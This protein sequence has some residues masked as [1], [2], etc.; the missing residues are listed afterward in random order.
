MLIRPLPYP[1]ELDVGYAGYVMRLNG[2]ASMKDLD[3][4]MREWAGCPDKSW[5]EVSRLELISK[6]AN[7][8]VMEFVL[9]HTTLPL[10]RSITSYQADL[11]HGSDR[12]KE[13]WWSTAMR[14]ARTGAYFCESCAQED[15]DFHGRSYWRRSHQVPGV[16]SCA[17]HGGPLS[18]CRDSVA[19]QQ[20][21]SHWIGNCEMVDAAWATAVEANDTIARYLAICDGLM[22]C[23][24]PFAVDHVRAVLFHK[25]ISLGLQ[26]S[27][28][29]V[30]A[31]LLSDMVIEQCGRQWLALVLP[32][33]AKKADKVALSKVDGVF[34]MKTSASTAFAY[35]LACVVL[36]E[37]AEAALN[38]LAGPLPPKGNCRQR[39]RKDIDT[40]ALMLEYGGQGGNFAKVAKRLGI[41]CASVAHRLSSMGLPNMIETECKSTQKALSAYLEEG[42][43]IQQSAER[44][45]VSQTELLDALRIL[46][47]KQMKALPNFGTIRPKGS[48]RY[49]PLMPDEARR[50]RVASDFPAEVVMDGI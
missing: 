17:K 35:I 7:L 5:R 15:L 46:A 4:L 11:P 3:C 24:Q 41:T 47:A 19:F 49:S 12:N 9:R 43:T 29:R 37:S 22:D 27:G 33:L 18:Y 13:I 2:M 45:G 6:V 16:L 44:G 39:K 38:A 40:D 21:P 50:V 48:P 8:S 20:A 42:C 10:R 1:D 31:P 34:Y 36:F 26:T 32:V 30:K 14:E 28:G 23:N 25:G